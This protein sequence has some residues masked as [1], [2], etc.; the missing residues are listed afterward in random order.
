MTAEKLTYNELRLG[1]GAKDAFLSGI[2]PEEIERKFPVYLN[3]REVYAGLNATDIVV[4][5]VLSGMNGLLVG[6]TGCGK[7]QLASDIARYYF[8]GERKD[9]GSALTIEGHPELEIYEEVLSE[10]SDKE[11][12]RVLNGN[13][14]AKY[15]N[16]EELNRC[17]PFAQNQFFSVGNGRLIR[18]GS[19]IPLGEDGYVSSLA[20]AN[21]GNGEYQGTFE[22]DKA[23]Y[24]RFGVI[25]DFDYEMFSP[26][27]EDRIFIDELVAANPNLKRAPIRD[28]SDKI[29]VAKEEI[30]NMLRNTS[31]EAKAVSQYL[32]L[33][34]ASYRGSDG[35]PV[36]KTKNWWEP[37]EENFTGGTRPL[38][39]L[40]RNPQPR[41]TQALM[42]YATSLHYLAKL[43]NPKRKINPIDTMFKA[44]ELTAAYQDVLNPLV[45]SQEYKKEHPVMM[46]RVAEQLKADFRKNEDYILTSFESARNRGDVFKQYFKVKGDGQTYAGE[47][48]DE[49]DKNKVTVVKPFNNLGEVNLTWV[50]SA[51][52]VQKKIHDM[53]VKQGKRGKKNKK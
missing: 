17:P 32:E 53:K 50:N 12:K 3:T 37:F 24:N 45:L 34:L 23:L 28:I 25:V 42:R 19:A 5:G 14:K 35:K 52:D 44:F 18:G 51:I 41:T 22:T 4:A 38:K 1:E 30:D 27:D 31:L 13:H 46:A 43:K 9:G 11:K 21:L 26:T 48:S 10:F 47:P 2:S 15:W 40:V 20:T 49:V 6:D 7:S 39:S 16:L 36:R 29:V 33:G 8:G